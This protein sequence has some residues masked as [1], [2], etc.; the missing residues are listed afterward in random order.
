[1]NMGS[2]SNSRN[3]DLRHELKIIF[4]AIRSIH[5]SLYQKKYPPDDV[6]ALMEMSMEKVSQIIDKTELNP[7]GAKQEDSHETK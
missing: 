7:K 2:I 6:R 5:E 3:Q 4:A 1:M